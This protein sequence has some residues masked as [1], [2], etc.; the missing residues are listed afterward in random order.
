MKWK[1]MMGYLC[2]TILRVTQRDAFSIQNKVDTGDSEHKLNYVRYLNE[3]NY[4]NKEHEK[5]NNIFF[6]I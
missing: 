4:N 2:N 3:M 5:V 6:I 1:H